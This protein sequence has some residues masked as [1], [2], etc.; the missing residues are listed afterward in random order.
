MR[1]HELEESRNECTSN[2]AKQEAEIA[3]LRD[4][5][6]V[7]TSQQ[8]SLQLQLGEANRRSDGLENERTKATAETQHSLHALQ[9][10][11]SSLRSDLAKKEEERD[12]LARELENANIARTN[13]EASMSDARSEAHALCAKVQELESE[14]KE[15]RDTLLRLN[16][17]QLEQPLPEALAQ[18]GAII[19]SKRSEQVSQNSAQASTVTCFLTDQETQTLGNVMHMNLQANEAITPVENREALSPS[20][21]G[22]I[23]PFSSIVEELEPTACLM[24]ENEPFDISSMLTQTPESVPSTKEL[25]IPARPEKDSPFANV[26]YQYKIQEPQLY[27]A[28]DIQQAPAEYVQER[29]HQEAVVEQVPVHPKQ[30]AAGRNVSFETRK[31]SAGDDNLQVPD[32]Q[33]SGGRPGLVVLSLSTNHPTRTN[34]WTYS[35][36]QRETT[37]E[38]QKANLSEAASSQMEDREDC[39]ETGKNKKTKTCPAPSN[40]VPQARTTT[41]LYPRRTSPARLASGSSRTRSSDAMSNQTGPARRLRKSARQTRGKIYSFACN[42][43]F[44]NVHSRKVQCSL[45]PRCL[46]ALHQEACGARYSWDLLTIYLP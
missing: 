14:I 17:A 41:E 44:F 10:R 42:L 1:I 45:Q 43:G 27:R 2:L 7:L 46:N 30:A 16:V 37:T 23:V 22:V 19:Q 29:T 25:I 38:Q 18:L 32:S 33:V 13:L 31:P 5:E 9:D 3:K 26:E 24:T 35:K 39:S 6:A 20:Q 28:S 11:L 4:Q 15:V 8:I 21:A 36:R 12:E 34:R 40:S